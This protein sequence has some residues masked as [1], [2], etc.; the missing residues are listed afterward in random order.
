[1]HYTTSNRPTGAKNKRL[2][3]RPAPF[4]RSFN[5]SHQ[6]RTGTPKR[7]RDISEKGR[8]IVEMLKYH[9]KTVITNHWHAYEIHKPIAIF[10]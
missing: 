2:T 3:I 9:K 7:Y 10:I 8:P 4:K 1:M 6:G 5:V